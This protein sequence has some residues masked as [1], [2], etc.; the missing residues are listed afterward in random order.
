MLATT[1]ISVAPFRTRIARFFNLGGRGRGAQ[2]KANRDRHRHARA[3]QTLGAISR[4]GGVYG[5]RAKTVLPSLVAQFM[6]V[7]LGSVR[8]QQGVIDH[9]GKLLA[10]HRR[11]SVQTDW[12]RIRQVE[13]RLE[14][15]GDGS[16][17]MVLETPGAIAKLRPLPEAGT[18]WA[19]PLYSLPA[20]PPI[21]AA[22]LPNLRR[23]PHEMRFAP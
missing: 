10:S 16:T 6:D 21:L 13:A 9:P 20:I 8:P 14:L 15:A 12:R 1:S 7:L 5:H 23:R 18:L 22:A 11:G 3:S 2:R 17:G 4:P 19:G